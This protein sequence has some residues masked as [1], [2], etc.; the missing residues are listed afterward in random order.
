[1]R[2]ARPDERELLR[3]ALARW[4]GPRIPN[5]HPQRF[6]LTPQQF[7]A[8]Q[9]AIG[10]KVELEHTSDPAV[11]LEIAMAH[12][13]EMRDYYARLERMEAP[14][15]LGGMTRRP[16]VF[17]FVA[18]GCPAC[19]SYTPVFKQAARG[20][21]HPVGVY[22]VATGGHAAAFANRMKIRATPTTIVMDSHGRMHRREGAIDAG[23]VRALL[24][25]AR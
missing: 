24:A 5:G 11:A 21:P 7:N 16:A 8:D 18:R 15:K 19:H 13:H 20:F 9:L 17:M 3:R 14:G 4:R 1:V 6:H 12:L 25:R 23:A 22:D 2:A 10:I